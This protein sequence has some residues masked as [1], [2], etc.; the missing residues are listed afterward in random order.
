M[1]S[2]RERKERDYTYIIGWLK[3]AR[4]IRVP[5]RYFWKVTMYCSRIL[6]NVRVQLSVIITSPTEG[7]ERWCFRRRRIYVGRGMFVDNFLAPIQV[8]LSV[9]KLRQSYL[10]PQE[11]RWL[12]SGKIN[13]KGQGQWGG[14]RS[15]E[16]PS[17]FICTILHLCHALGNGDFWKFWHRGQ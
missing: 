7:D 16:R 5:V 4:T 6:Y 1:D 10:W 8:R 3:H 17:T 14:M 12:H 11:T 15:I 13:V 9:T 2:R